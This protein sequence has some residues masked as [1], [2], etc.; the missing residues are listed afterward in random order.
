MIRIGKTKSCICSVK[1]LRM[2]R[3][4]SSLSWTYIYELPLFTT[5]P[6]DVSYDNWE[7]KYYLLRTSS[8]KISMSFLDK[9]NKAWDS[10][11]SNKTL[12]WKLI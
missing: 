8:T 6:K 2:I 12:K 11:Y 4:C 1:E 10:L 7:S 3:D 9:V 5:N